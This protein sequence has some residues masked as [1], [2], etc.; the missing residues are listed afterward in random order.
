MVNAC[1]GDLTGERWVSNS[2]PL[3]ILDHDSLLCVHAHNCAHICRPHYT[4][5]S[6]SYNHNRFCCD[7]YCSSVTVLVV[8][9]GNCCLCSALHQLQRVYSL[10]HCAALTQRS[11]FDPL[12]SALLQLLLLQLPLPLLLLL[13][14]LLPML[15]SMPM[16]PLTLLLFASFAYIL[17]FNAAENVTYTTVCVI[18]LMVLL[19]G[20]FTQIIGVD[21]IFGAFIAGL[22][23]PR[24]GDLAIVLTEKIEDV[25]TVKFNHFHFVSTATLDV[26]VQCMLLL[27]RCDTRVC[28]VFYSYGVDDKQLH[29][30]CDH[31]L[32]SL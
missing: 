25:V 7:C 4:E 26:F 30:L 31:S 19:S 20:W 2:S 1:F 23:I 17:R 12:A 11:A 32:V 27:C 15:L 14:L 10:C 22:I 6:S 24:D 18:F 5:V 21:A 3:C 9:L 29:E 16:Q 8:L 28:S 13:P